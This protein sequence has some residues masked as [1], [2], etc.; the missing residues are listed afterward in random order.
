[1][2]KAVVS[3]DIEFVTVF[4]D[5]CALQALPGTVIVPYEFFLP[6]VPKL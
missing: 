2:F 4:L 6:W 3:A 5:Y 1:M